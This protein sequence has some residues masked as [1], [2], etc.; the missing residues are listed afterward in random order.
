MS[1]RKTHFSILEA[2]LYVTGEEGISSEQLIE[3]LELPLDE[4]HPLMEA[5]KQHLNESEERGLALVEVAGVYQ[6]TTKPKLAN[7]IEKLVEAPKPTSLSQAALETLAVI[8]YK[9]P[10]SRAEV[11]DIRGVKS[12]KAIHTLVSKGLI[13]EVGRAEGT[14]RAILYGVTS[15]FLSHFGL[16]SIEELPPMPETTE[17]IK[18][19][20]AD[21]FYERF[22]QTVLEF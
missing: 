13:K 18:E 3:V 17:E 8:A 7:Y 16:N 22:Q 1:D 5:F 15:H 10:V 4:I 21:L 12:E 2:L 6:L 20:E 14:G 11:E 9:Q 19:G